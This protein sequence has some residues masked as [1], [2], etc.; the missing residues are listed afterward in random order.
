MSTCPV[1]NMG[2]LVV[3]DV[4]PRGKHCIIIDHPDYPES[5]I[6]KIFNVY[7]IP[8]FE[9]KAVD[10]AVWGDPPVNR[11]DHNMSVGLKDA[12]KIQN[13]CWLEGLAPRVYGI[14]GVLLNNKK[15]LAQEIEK[16]QH[17]SKDEAEAYEVYKKVKKLGETYGWGNDK[18]DVS[19]VD[20]MDGQLVDF[21]TFHPQDEH[22][23][24]IKALYFEL[25]RYGK[26]YYQDVPELGLH[27][28]PRKSED[29]VKYM[30]LDEIDFK[31]KSVADFGCA[32]GFFTRYAKSRGANKVH[33]YDYEDVKGS[34]NI[35]AARIIA[36]EL[37]YWNIDYID[38]DLRTIQLLP[39]SYDITFFLSM[40]YHIGIPEWLPMVTKE[41]CIFE[42]NSKNRDALPTL[43]KM[44]SKVV[45]VGEALD[46]GNKPIYHCYV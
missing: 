35:K 44:F 29:R 1:Y 33:G 36:N 2:G 10:M 4:F 6:L 16:R 46:H 7:P 31:S 3:Y 40:N 43:E 13:Y 11:E 22:L 12:T 30:K 20:V 23:D 37:E 27:G 15:C 42:D 18:D 19:S 21:N 14:C 5:R 39:D 32:G 26:V 45:K 41:V 38:Q 17:H 25:A 24:K 9:L 28:G 8:E 34:N